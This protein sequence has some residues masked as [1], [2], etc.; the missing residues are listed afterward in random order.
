M[1]TQKKRYGHTH[2]GTNNLGI[3]GY[4]LPFEY[5]LTEVNNV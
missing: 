3:N 5:P 2:Q 1:K 4:N